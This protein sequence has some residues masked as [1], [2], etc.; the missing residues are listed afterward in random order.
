MKTFARLFVAIYVIR[1]VIHGAEL[2][3]FPPNGG[4]K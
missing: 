1:S 3:V 4:R 2:V